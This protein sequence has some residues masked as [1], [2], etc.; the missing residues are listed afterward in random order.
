MNPSELVARGREEVEGCLAAGDGFEVS[1]LDGTVLPTRALLIATGGADE[2]PAIP[3][4]GEQWGMPGHQAVMFCQWSPRITNLPVGL[5]VEGQDCRN[6]EAVGIP[7]VEGEIT[8]V[9]SDG[10]RVVGVRATTT[11]PRA[12]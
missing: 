3:G 5:P 2:L 1:L 9:E 4:L 8:R 10:G 7:I 11:T 12:G 6:M